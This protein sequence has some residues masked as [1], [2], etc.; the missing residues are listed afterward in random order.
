MSYTTDRRSEMSPWIRNKYPEMAAFWDE[1]GKAFNLASCDDSG[2]D[3]VDHT[4]ESISQ[5]NYM[6]DILM[7]LGALPEDAGIHY[8][9]AT[10]VYA[11]PHRPHMTIA[12][13]NI[14]DLMEQWQKGQLDL[15]G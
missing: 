6:A 9:K 10:V 3:H 14:L 15:G 8:G 1:W 2:F 11:D 7:D 12:R 4:P 13:Y 5:L